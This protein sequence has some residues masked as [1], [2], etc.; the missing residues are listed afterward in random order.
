MNSEVSSGPPPWP[1][2]EG[3]EPSPNEPQQS[4]V[5]TA[6]EKGRFSFKMMNSDSDFLPSGFEQDICDHGPGAPPL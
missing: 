4:S 2:K 5:Y 6:S 1:C 3:Y